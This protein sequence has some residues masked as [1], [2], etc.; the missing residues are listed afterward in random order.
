MA[1]TEVHDQFLKFVKGSEAQEA[2]VGSETKSRM[3]PSEAG[4]R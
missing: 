2:L 1:P 3:R 4:V